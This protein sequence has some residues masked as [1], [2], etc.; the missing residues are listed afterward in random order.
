VSPINDLELTEHIRRMK[1]NLYGD[2]NY[3][4]QETEENKLSHIGIDELKGRALDR[5]IMRRLKAIE[6]AS[7]LAQ[8]R[9]GEIT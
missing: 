8:A 5:E 7:Q 4:E 6:I 9:L 2:K 3:R 1:N